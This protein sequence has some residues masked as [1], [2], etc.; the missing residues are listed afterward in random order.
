L[1][2]IPEGLNYTKIIDNHFHTMGL[3]KLDDVHLADYFTQLFAAGF[4]RA[5][6]SGAAMHN[7]ASRAALADKFAELYLA[8]GF[9]PSDTYDDLKP[10]MSLLK[11]Q[12]VHPKN[13]CVG[14]IGLD[15]S[16][17][18]LEAAAQFADKGKEFQQNL[19][20]E[21][22][23]I[24]YNANLPVM[25]HVRDAHEDALALVKNAGVSQGVVHCFT[26]KVE[27][28]RKW[29]DAGFYLSFSGIIT[30]KKAPHV[31][32]SAAFCPTD[33]VLCETDAPWLAP[34]PHRGATN[35]PAYV[36]YVYQAMSELQDMPLSELVDK[37]DKNF[38]TL[39]KLKS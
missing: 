25:L 8:S 13:V 26:G 32:A 12:M 15:Y 7:F 37:V 3:L 38:T 18:E 22:L 11:E 27:I 1:F 4:G 17:F 20:S 36:A 14:E 9:H 6:D 10:N 16:Y 5:L 24:A 33:R 31:Q 35:H 21:Q 19:M 29:L 23:E 28:A 34:V 2:T 30:F 39:Y